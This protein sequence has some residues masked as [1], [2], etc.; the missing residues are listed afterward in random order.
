M[1]EFHSHLAVNN[2]SLAYVSISPELYKEKLNFSYPQS[3][4]GV[5]CGDD[6]VQHFSQQHMCCHTCEPCKFPSVKVNSHNCTLCDHLKFQ[7]P[8]R[9]R[10]ACE[11]VQLPNNFDVLNDPLAL[12]ILVLCGCGLALEILTVILYMVYLATPIIRASGRELSFVTL[13][14][15]L[16]GLI[17]SGFLILTPTSFNCGFIR[18][19]YGL[20]YSVCYAAILVKT[21]RIERIFS[22]KTNG[23][24]KLK[25]ISPSSQLI[26][27][28][29]LCFVQA[30]INTIWLLFR[31]PQ[32]KLRSEVDLL[33]ETVKI[34]Q[35]CETFEDLEMGVTLIYPAVLLLLCLYYA[36]RTRK[37]PGAFSEAKS[38]FIATHTTFVLWLAF[39]PIFFALD[40]VSIRIFVLGMAIIVNA[41]VTL[42][43]MFWPKLYVALWRPEK[44]TKGLVMGS[45]T[46][47]GAKETSLGSPRL[48]E[49]EP[50]DDR[51]NHSDEL[52]DFEEMECCR[53]DKP[54]QED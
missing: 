3:H 34:Y 21:N 51:K 49:S 7:Q 14:G 12:V 2:H 11:S 29:L 6:Q 50:L 16:V 32:T 15:L 35:Y 40:K 28:G 48:P 26:L 30:A 23:N 36:F 39:V 43:C 8:N 31:F 4:C 9:W 53:L 42:V 38:I 25:Y 37:L 44:N 27:V 41:N 1:I 5:E 17:S 10:N 46:N 18:F 24:K 52:E 33:H 19:F 45:S 22:T 20:S 54:E 13:L 47:R